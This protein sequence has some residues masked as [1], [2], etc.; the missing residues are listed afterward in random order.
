MLFF[1]ILS[2]SFGFGLF[3]TKTQKQTAGWV[4]FYAPFAACKLLVW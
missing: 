2:L 1:W 4:G 3:E